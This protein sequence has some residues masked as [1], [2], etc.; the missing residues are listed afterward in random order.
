VES[1]PVNVLLALLASFIAI[2]LGFLPSQ[3]LPK[4]FFQR[5]IGVA[6]VL[7]MAVGLM[8]P[9]I[10]YYTIGAAVFCIVA[11]Y[12]WGKKSVL[13][14]RVWQSAAAAAS[15]TVGVMMVLIYSPPAVPEGMPRAAQ[16]WFI[17]GPYLAGASL[18]AG[19][20]LAAL[21]WHYSAV[22]IDEKRA[23]HERNLLRTILS[24][25]LMALGVQAVFV[26]TAMWLLPMFYPDFG[27][28]F[29][30]ELTKFGPPDG[31]GWLLIT[32]MVLGFLLPFLMCAWLYNHVRSTPASRWFW[33]PLASMAVLIVGQLLALQLHV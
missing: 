13:Q 31:Q 3:N 16:N 26:L 9:A 23:E 22:E 29:V 12:F 18:G 27:S 24:W 11:W 2:F 5:H 32:R 21:A 1:F 33:W 19:Y 7:W 28:H 10:L 20:V 25:N 14:A 6:A 4:F 15:V 30:E 8:M 17:A